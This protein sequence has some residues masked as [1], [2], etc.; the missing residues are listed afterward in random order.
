MVLLMALGAVQHSDPDPSLLG[1]T[2][3]Y[4][5]VRGLGVTWGKTTFKKIQR[6]FAKRPQRP[7]WAPN[8]TAGT[9]HVPV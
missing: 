5:S 6:G 9:A 7:N 1:S 3:L 4:P 8:L 2:S